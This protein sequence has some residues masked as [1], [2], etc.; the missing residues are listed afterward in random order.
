MSL[1]NTL[2]QQY[3]T[4]ITCKDGTVKYRVGLAVNTESPECGDYVPEENIL[5]IYLG[6]EDYEYF[7]MRDILNYIYKHYT[8]HPYEHM[9]DWVASAFDRT[10]YMNDDLETIA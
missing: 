10:W 3:P 4:K 8:D 7:G 1:T 9:D 6:K 5:V 2:D